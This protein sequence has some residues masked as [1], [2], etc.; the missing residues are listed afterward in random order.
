MS[1]VDLRG[2]VVHSAVVA[3][4]VIVA[5]T[6]AVGVIRCAVSCVPS[7]LVCEH[8]HEPRHTHTHDSARAHT[9]LRLHTSGCERETYT[10]TQSCISA[11]RFGN[12]CVVSGRL[13]VDLGQVRLVTILLAA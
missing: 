5:V 7:C 12:Q 11:R 8:T 3:V 2:A 4:R 10:R 9:R 6:V 1:T 13:R